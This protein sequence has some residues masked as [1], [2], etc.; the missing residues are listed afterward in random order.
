[1]VC[2]FVSLWRVGVGALIIYL[3]ALKK[4]ATNMRSMPYIAEFTTKKC[5]FSDEKKIKY[6]FH[7]SAQNI[8]CG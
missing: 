3:A 4:G 5:K 7:I 1:M 6:F 2:V 8:D